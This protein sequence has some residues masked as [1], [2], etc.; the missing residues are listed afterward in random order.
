[1]DGPREV[2]DARRGRGSFDAACRAKPEIPDAIR[3][4]DFAP[5]VGWL[6]TNLHGHGSRLSTRDL[7]TQ[8]TGRPLDP[9]VFERHLE[10]RYL[11]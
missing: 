5:L 4:G 1:M 3:Q 7:L 8:A 6:R 9:K 11:S 2:C 10:T